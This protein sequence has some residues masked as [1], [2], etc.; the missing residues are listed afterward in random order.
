MRRAGLGFAVLTIGALGAQAQD[1]DGS[2]LL[3]CRAIP[4]EQRRL[5]CY[6]AII[7]PSASPLSK[8]EVVP[9]EELRSYA[10]SYRGRL[11]ETE[12]WLKPGET[13]LFLGKDADDPAPMPVDA[14]NLTR[15]ARETLLEQCGEGCRAKVQGVVRPV[16]FTTGIVADSVIAP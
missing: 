12:G 1:G 15:H 13:Y 10:L 14:A 4:D 9:L 7:V 5:A 8:Y 16:N 3:R 11:I 6:D 2:D